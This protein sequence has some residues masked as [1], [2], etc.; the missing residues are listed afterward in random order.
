MEWKITMTSGVKWKSLW[1]GLTLNF[2]FIHIAG[3][4]FYMCI[5]NLYVWHI[6]IY[7]SMFLS[8]GFLLRG[9]FYIFHL[10]ICIIL[11]H[12]NVSHMVFSY[13]SHNHSSAIN[14]VLSTILEAGNK[15]YSLP[16]RNTWF[17]DGDIHENKY[18]KLMNF[19]KIMKLRGP[20]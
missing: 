3:R 15:R 20:K 14:C 2:M 16:S 10:T 4:C 9:C 12:I 6:Y 13:H 7:N 1:G 11:T 8:F 19:L 17:S 5:C 18:L